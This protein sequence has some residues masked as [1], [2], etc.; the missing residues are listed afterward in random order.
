[1]PTLTFHVHP[2][3][4][5]LLM[6]NVRPSVPFQIANGVGANVLCATQPF[7]VDTGA[8]HCL[9]DEAVISGWG[10]HPKRAVS[11]R[12]ASK[13]A[14]QQGQIYD[15]ALELF[16]GNNTA[17]WSHRALEVTALPS[18]RFGGVPFKGLIGRDVLEQCRLVYDGPHRDVSITW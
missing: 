2:K 13:Q 7:L 17:T 4:G 10:L 18:H 3:D 6:V 16:V 8:S 14:Q 5:P 12:S 9:I 11:V 1:M 15:L